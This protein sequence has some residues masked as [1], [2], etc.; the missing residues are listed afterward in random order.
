M[1]GAGTITSAQLATSTGVLRARLDRLEAD[2]ADATRGHPLAPFASTTAP[3][4]RWNAAGLDER[5]AVLDALLHVRVLSP[6]R[7]ARRFDPETVE[8]IWRTVLV[9]PEVVPHQSS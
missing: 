4:T 5:R 8:I 2:L 3:V 9:R 7:G 6:G 1:F